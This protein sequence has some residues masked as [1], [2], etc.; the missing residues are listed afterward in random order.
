M[1]ID[2]DETPM[3]TP[4]LLNAGNITGGTARTMSQFLNTKRGRDSKHSNIR[5][6]NS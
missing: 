5:N 4:R 2:Y 1:P 6:Y 3:S